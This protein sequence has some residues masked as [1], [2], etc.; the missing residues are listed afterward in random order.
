MA[1]TVRFH[2]CGGPEVLLVEDLDIPA[3]AAGE[4]RLAVKAIGLNRVEAMFR[5]GQ[6]MAPTFPSRIGY[7]AAGVV[8]AVGPDVSSFAPG[9]RVA[10]LFGSSMDRYGTYG[11]Q[12]LYPADRL[13]RIPDTLSFVDAAASWMQY[14]TAFALVEV[15]HVRAG[16]FVVVTAASSSVGIAAIQIANAEGATPIAVTRSRSKASVLKSLGAAHVIC[17]DEEN[18]PDA[19]R[20]LTGGHGARV[21]FDAVA[22]PGL[23]GL[24]GAV[25][26]AG[27]IIVYGMLAGITAEILLPALMHHNLT[28]R[29]F[30]A[31]IFVEHADSRA[32]M[33]DYINR[34]LAS[35]ALRPIV[36]RTFELSRIAEAHRYLES[37]AQV[38][39]IVVTTDTSHPQHL[40]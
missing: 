36:D 14:G 35:G 27:I 34:K 15:A 11:E 12:I 31:N 38:G 28:L 6:F 40:L 4:A 8:E 3:P 1:K 32:R 37:N 26:P 9:D 23:P 30:A 20:A 16:D 7:E 13:V 21:V 29:G 2:S 17:S 19:I 5:G 22:G 39:K 24:V 10:A 18:V 33:V 25:A